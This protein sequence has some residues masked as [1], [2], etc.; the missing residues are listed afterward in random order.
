MKDWKTTVA[1]ALAALFV[2]AGIILPDAV[3]PES[4]VAA[5]AAVVQI[6]SGI[7]ALIAVLTGWFAKDPE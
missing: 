2:V 7:G 5:N 6:L 3:D 4:Q 1:G